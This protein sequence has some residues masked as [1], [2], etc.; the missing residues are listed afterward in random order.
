[1]PLRIPLPALALIVVWVLA[2]LVVVGA[3]CQQNEPPRVQAPPPE[4]RTVSARAGDVEIVV[5]AVGQIRPVDSI[6]LSAEVAAIVREIHFEEGGIVEAGQ[7]LIQLDESRARSELQSARAVRDRAA[8]QLER[9]EKAAS[10]AAA[11]LAEIDTVRT[12]LAQ[13]EAQ[14]ELAQIRVSDHRIVAPFGGRVGLRL[15]SPGAYIQPGT[16]LTT[17]ATVDPIEVEFAVPEMHLAALR[18]GLDLSAS[19]PAFDREFPAT[20]RVVQPEIDPSTRTALVLARAPN[21]EGLLRP[22]MFVNVRLVIGTRSNAVMVPEASLQFRGSQASLYVVDGDEASLR[23][24]VT[25]ER[26][27]AMVEIMEGVQPGEK[28]VTLGLQRIRDGARVRAVPDRATAIGPDLDPVEPEAGKAGET[29]EAVG[30]EKT[31]GG[32]SEVGEPGGRG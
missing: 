26:R 23:R 6:T 8:R 32:M 1:M 7:L 17:L 24:V 2:G 18:P 28:V 12:E 13:A 30:G 20:V 29:G 27:G 11:V 21:P 16:A 9:F 19:S 22:G 10:T 15:V 31:V 25:G 5:R 14:Y 4:V 3:G